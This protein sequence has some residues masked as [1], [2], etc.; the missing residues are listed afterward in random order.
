MNKIIVRDKIIMCGHVNSSYNWLCEGKEYNSVESFL[1]DHGYKEVF[2][3]IY[4]EE[5]DFEPLERSSLYQSYVSAFESQ[6]DN[7]FFKILYK[8]DDDFAVHLT[9]NIYLYHLISTKEKKYIPPL[10]HGFTQ[11]A[12]NILVIHG[13]KVMKK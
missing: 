12:K 5:I 1:K 13:G 2:K 6:Q 10:F 7:D 9:R 3:K 8:I 4:E 11:T